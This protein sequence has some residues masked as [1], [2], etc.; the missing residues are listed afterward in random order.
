MESMQYHYWVSQ[1]QKGF[2]LLEDEDDYKDLAEETLYME[3]GLWVYRVQ[4]VI[5]AHLH[6]S[7]YIIN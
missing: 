4:D 3:K 5:Y 1:C 7:T 2:Q 6:P